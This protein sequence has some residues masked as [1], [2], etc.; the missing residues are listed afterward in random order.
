MNVE[1]YETN[2]YCLSDRWDGL[3]T[4]EQKMV[5]GTGD[6]GGGSLNSLHHRC[7]HVITNS[8]THNTLH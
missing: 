7:R 3:G 6:R 1:S 8:V 5:R 4:F 2:A